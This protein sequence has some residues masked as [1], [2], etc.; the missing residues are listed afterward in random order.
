MCRLVEEDK[1]KRLI[2]ESIQVDTLKVSEEDTIIITLDPD[3]INVSESQEIYECIK[4]FIF[5]SNNIILKLKG[6]E[7]D[8]THNS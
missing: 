2:K 7:I 4:K 5:P 1:L 6:I 3:I 8:V